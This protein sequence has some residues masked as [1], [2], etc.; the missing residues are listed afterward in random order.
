M[1]AAADLGTVQRAARAATAL[2]IMSPLL[3]PAPLYPPATGE[4][5][6]TNI[7][8]LYLLQPHLPVWLVVAMRPSTIP[9]LYF[10][11]LKFPLN[12]VLY[13]SNDACLGINNKN[14][15]MAV[16]HLSF[17]QLRQKL[18]THIELTSRQR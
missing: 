10:E 8:L 5:R 6:L 15:T 4:H 1:R 14:V 11:S 18:T 13:T 16:S 17:S 2:L 9:R 3:H 12:Q 7:S